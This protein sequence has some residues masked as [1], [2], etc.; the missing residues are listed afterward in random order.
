MHILTAPGAAS[1]LRV[2][3]SL[4]LHMYAGAVRLHGAVRLTVTVS[5]AYK[6]QPVPAHKQGRA[7]PR[8][9]CG[10][11]AVVYLSCVYLPAMRALFLAVLPLHVPLHVSATSEAEALLDMTHGARVLGC[12]GQ[13]LRPNPSKDMGLDS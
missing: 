6:G 5:C 1:M 7:C 8:P 13:G 3:L 9:S 12:Q 2:C 4:C 10:S 11:R